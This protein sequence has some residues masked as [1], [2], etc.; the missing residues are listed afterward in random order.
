L[1]RYS[2]TTQSDLDVLYYKIWTKRVQL[3]NEVQLR[4]ET[5]SIV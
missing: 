4:T 1:T 3:P 2:K 5:G